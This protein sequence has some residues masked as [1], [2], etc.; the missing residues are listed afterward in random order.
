ML[1]GLTGLPAGVG[2]AASEEERES[3]GIV[4][5]AEVIIVR[6]KTPEVPQVSEVTSVVE[7]IAVEVAAVAMKS[8]KVLT[9][10]EAVA[11][12]DFMTAA[13]KTSMASVSTRHRFCRRANRHHR[14]QGCYRQDCR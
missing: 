12:E 2:V 1:K 13:V 6:P 7:T 14:A 9:T 10:V 11:P 4:G 3:A 5:V 8:A